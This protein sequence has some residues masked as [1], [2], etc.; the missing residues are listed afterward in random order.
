MS[1]TST[2]IEPD[3][4]LCHF[5]MSDGL[6]IVGEVYGPDDG[7]PVLLAHGGGQTRYAWTNV[8]RRLGDR[9]WK[10]VAI[11]LRGHGESD[12]SKI[13]DYSHERYALDLVEV[14]GQIGGQPVLVGASLGGNSGMLA[15]GTTGKDAFRAL[16]MVD[17][18]PKLDPQGMK[19]I[20]GFLDRHIDEGFGSFEEASQ[21]ISDYLPGRR[22]RQNNIASLGRYL[23]QRDDGRYGWH[24]DPEFVRGVR[25]TRLNPDR[26]A[27]ISDAVLAT[28]IP[29][30]LI[31]GSDS[32][33]VNTEAVEHFL[34]LAPHAEFRDVLG[35]SHMIVGDRNDIF[36]EALTG[37]LER[38]EDG[39]ARTRDSV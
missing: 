6:S 36:A 3:A 8:A 14:A 23:R 29:M 37:F 16:V 5:T 26:V 19:K 28:S 27:R 24:W 7:A 9:G 4:R 10:S 22:G 18:T 11:D 20:I 38:V 2:N 33:L 17:V 32:E 34:E 21:A 39:T 12:W 31:R 35:A 15:A 25:N 1:Q 13:G 30:M